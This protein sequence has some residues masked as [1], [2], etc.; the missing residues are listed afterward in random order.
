[1][2][3]NR[4]GAGPRHSITSPVKVH[5]ISPSSG[6]DEASAEAQSG[7]V[8]AAAT[9]LVPDP[10]QV[11][12]DGADADVKLG[13]DLGSSQGFPLEQGQANWTVGQ[14]D[15][16]EIPGLPDPSYTVTWQQAESAM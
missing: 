13:R 10:V 8:G 12:A 6:S 4:Y 11:R 16:D 7:Q 9:G 1:M 14:Q 2:A 15:C 3:T 5:S